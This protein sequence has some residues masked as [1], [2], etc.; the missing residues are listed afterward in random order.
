MCYQKQPPHEP[1]TAQAKGRYSGQVAGFQQ[2][3]QSGRVTDAEAPSELDVSL[4]APCSNWEAYRL[5]LLRGVQGANNRSGVG[6]CEQKEGARPS[7]EHLVVGVEVFDP[8]Q[9]PVEVGPLNEEFRNP[10][11]GVPALCFEPCEGT[12][13]GVEAAR[14]EVVVGGVD[15]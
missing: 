15:Q 3:R 2:G 11:G 9:P 4:F 1:P 14:N 8:L 10:V 5:Q 7:V 12:F 6:S 13:D